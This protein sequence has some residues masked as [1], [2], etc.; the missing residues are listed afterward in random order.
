MKLAL[1][2][3]IFL[4]THP[5]IHLSMYTG[6]VH[7]LIHS[8]TYILIHLSTYLSIHPSIH[9]FI[10]LLYFHLSMY[11]LI[12][13]GD[14]VYHSEHAGVRRS[15]WIWFPPSFFIQILEI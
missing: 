1:L 4:P 8:Y 14:W 6:Y 7:P 13:K 9:P 2:S 5:L 15:L 11:P 3:I 12:I 10:V